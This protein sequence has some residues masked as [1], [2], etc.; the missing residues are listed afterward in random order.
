MRVECGLRIRSTAIRFL[1]SASRTGFDAD[2]QVH[3]AGCFEQGH[4]RQVDFCL[5][6]KIFSPIDQ[7]GRIRAAASGTLRVAGGGGAA[8]EL[9]Y[10]GAEVAPEALRFQRCQS[11]SLCKTHPAFRELLQFFLALIKW[12][13]VPNLILSPS[14]RQAKLN[15]ARI[16][17]RNDFGR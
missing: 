15:A 9:R 4:V 7:R 6:E 17:P 8:A 13:S 12:Q 11:N 1:S 14:C 3:S 2:R 10:S 5:R 16:Y